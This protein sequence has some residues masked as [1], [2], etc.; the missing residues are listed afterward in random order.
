MTE[1]EW[2]E[3]ADSW[4][5]RGFLHPGKRGVPSRV[6]DRKMRLEME[7]SFDLAAV[8]GEAALVFQSLDRASGEQNRPSR[9][10][11]ARSVRVFPALEGF[12]SRRPWADK[13]KTPD[14]REWLSSRENPG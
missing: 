13:K 2:L 4:A 3:S 5:M 9:W 10:A 14:F 11:S 6:S 8:T 7:D 1:Q 12:K